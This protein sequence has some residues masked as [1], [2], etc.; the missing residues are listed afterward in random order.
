MLHASVLKMENQCEVIKA[1]K[2]IFIFF[3]NIMFMSCF[4]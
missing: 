3:V 1:L 2:K 4:A